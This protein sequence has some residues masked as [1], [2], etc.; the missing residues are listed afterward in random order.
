MCY[1]YGILC[2]IEDRKRVDLN[3]CML[4][5]R[6]CAEACKD[7]QPILGQVATKPTRTRLL[8]VACSFFYFCPTHHPP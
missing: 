8:S 6:W 3:K 4:E 2:E 5:V 7:A 1:I